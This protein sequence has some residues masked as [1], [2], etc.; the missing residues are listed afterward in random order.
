MGMYDRPGT[1][2]SKLA[3]IN[4]LPAYTANE[5]TDRALDQA[6]VLIESGM[7]YMQGVPF[8]GASDTI[9]G[10]RDTFG[11][12]ITVPSLC[13][14]V[15]I[16]GDSFNAEDP[17][18]A[19]GAIGFKFRIY[20]KGAKLDSIINGQFIKE[21]SVA[22]AM[23]NDPATFNLVPI[24]P[25]MLMSPFVI[26]HPGSLQMEVTNLSSFSCQVQ[27]M[28]GLAVPINPTST[29]EQ[30]LKGSEQYA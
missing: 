9:I 29:S 6:R 17:S 5:G 15:S 21:T 4:N 23:N 20:D 19:T 27:L 7:Y 14:V 2:Y 10:A 24:G 16:T 13:Y 12:V 25:Y 22:P 11:G 3:F 18:N 30:I 1:P 28:L 8:P 26:L